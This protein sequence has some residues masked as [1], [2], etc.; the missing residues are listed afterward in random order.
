MESSSSAQ[1][2]A[3]DQLKDKAH[4]LLKKFNLL[5]K[6]TSKI[7]GALQGT[8]EL[9][10]NV[11]KTS[12]PEERLRLEQLLKSLDDSQDTHDMAT[13]LSRLH[14]HRS[15]E[16]SLLASAQSGLRTLIDALQSDIELISAELKN[17]SKKLSLIKVEVEGL[18][19]SRK[20]PATLKVY[21]DHR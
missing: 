13:Y 17:R 20:I 18:D 8:V 9:M 1:A 21:P 15:T 16:H 6:E 4:Q 19:S 10:K 5:V 2:S 3:L 7:D 14:A 12:S 11:A